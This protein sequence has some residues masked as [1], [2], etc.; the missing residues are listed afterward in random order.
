MIPADAEAV[1]ELGR[2]LSNW[3]RWGADDQ[4]G[5]LNLITSEAIVAAST[6]VHRGVV[7]SCAIEFNANGPVVPAGTD[8][9]L[10]TS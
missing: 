9:T 2:K 5:A 8:T 6:L 4:L 1:R 7:I 10:G 3:G